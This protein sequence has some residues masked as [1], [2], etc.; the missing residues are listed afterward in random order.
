MNWAKTTRIA[1]VAACLALL[2]GSLLLAEQ[3]TVQKHK[4]DI[5]KG[6]GSMYLPPLITVDP[7]TSVE[8]LDHEGRW[9]KVQVGSTVGYV[10]QTALDGTS[11]TSS[12]T[13]A[14]GSQS[15]DVTASTAAKGWD[16]TNWSQSHGYSRAG[17]EKLNAIR[18]RIR[19]NPGFWEK[20]KADGNVGAQ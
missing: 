16:E 20:F 1:R 9:C 4:V 18:D 15:T 14:T 5:L 17:L 11:D 7:G 3:V 8:V 2:S 10:L 19:D 12:Y 6:K 13:A